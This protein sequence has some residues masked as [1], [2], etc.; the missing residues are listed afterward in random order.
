MGIPMKI[1]LKLLLTLGLI[2]SS[3][4]CAVAKPPTEPTNYNECLKVPHI[5]TKQ[6]P[7]SCITKSGQVFTDN[8][9]AAEVKICVDRCGNGVCEEIV[10]FGSGCTCSENSDSCPNDCK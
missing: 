8:S 6:Q 3:T 1:I 9:K 5:L 2:V 7:P 4:N 10:C